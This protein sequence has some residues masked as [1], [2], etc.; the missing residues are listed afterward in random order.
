M[1]LPVPA[2][3]GQQVFEV[4]VVALFF[5]PPSCRN[6]RSTVEALHKLSEAPNISYSRKN[7]YSFA[8]FFMFCFPLLLEETAETLLK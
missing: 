2:V 6:M 4:V 7:F 1:F 3:A 8:L 5:F